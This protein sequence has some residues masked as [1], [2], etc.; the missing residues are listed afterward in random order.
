MSLKLRLLAAG[1]G[2]S[3]GR[4]RADQAFEGEASMSKFA[5]VGKLI[6]QSLDKFRKPGL[7]AIRPGYHLENGWPVGDPLIV[8]L[9][10][11]KRGEAAAYGLPS[12]LGG[13]PVEVREAS[14]QERLR[15]TRPDVQAL[16]Q[17]RARN[18]LHAPDFPFEY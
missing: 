14:P 8:A 3:H 7:L 6:E 1:F 16:A 10:G 9:V 17:A 2:Q 12:Q 15:V 4:R 18:E 5:D 11:A 13:V